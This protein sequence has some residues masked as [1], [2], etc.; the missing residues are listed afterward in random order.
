MS[1][2]IILMIAKKISAFIIAIDS[3]KKCAYADLI[4]II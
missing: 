2:L 3:D 4:F 1:A